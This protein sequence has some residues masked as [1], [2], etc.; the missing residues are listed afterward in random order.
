MTGGLMQLV[1]YGAQDIYL[2]GDPMITH[3]KTVY[4]RHTNFSIDTI[5]QSFNGDV[6]F[7]TTVSAII[8]RQGDLISGMYIKTTLPELATSIDTTVSRWTE[9]V[10]HFLIKQVEIEIGGQLIDR[11]YG[12]WLDIWAQ[13]TVPAGKQT[14]YLTMIGQGRLDAL[15]RPTGL[16]K[17]VDVGMTLGKTLY[18]PLQFWFCRDIGLALPLIALQYHIVKINV[19]F[20]DAVDIVRTGT[21][22]GVNRLSNTSLWVDYIFLDIDERKKFSQTAHEYLIDQLQFNGGYAIQANSSRYS[23]A[24]KKI[25]LSFNHPIKEIVWVVQPDNYITGN[26]RQPGNYTAIIGQAPVDQVDIRIDNLASLSLVTLLNNVKLFNQS[27]IS[28]P[29]SLNPVVSSKLTLN[30]H[31]RFTTQPGDYFNKLIPMK[32]HTNI[33]QS[34]GINVYSFA[35]KPE[36]V[37]PSGTCNFSKID[38]AYLTL[39][40][41]TL[42]SSGYSSE[43]PESLELTKN[44]EGKDIIMGT[45][46]L[47]EFA[48]RLCKVNV[49]AVNFNVLRIMSGLGGVAF[50]N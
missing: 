34:P 11:H 40:V 21:T 3:F 39:N 44:E 29:G 6:N 8:S 45:T 38:N 49:Y 27:S 19:K 20:A 17:D 30:G 9:N 13:L 41:A 36:D 32:C 1:A 35:L 33:P 12:E 4:R 50:I 47:A 42:Q 14:G 48:S 18:I 37:Q 28:P 10:G 24:L 25:P 26:N 22:L 46:N 5:E 16:Q 23:T 7:G 15:G 31:D 43:Y 2:T